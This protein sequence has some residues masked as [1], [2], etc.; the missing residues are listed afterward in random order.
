MM[1]QVLVHEYSPLLW[2]HWAKER[3]WMRR[4]AGWAGG[5]ESVDQFIQAFSFS[6][7][8]S[9]ILDHELLGRRRI[10]PEWFVVAK[11]HR[12]NYAA[13]NAP[14]HDAR[15]PNIPQ[16]HLNGD[17]QVRHCLPDRHRTPLMGAIGL[18]FR[19]PALEIV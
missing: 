2:R 9:F 15:R 1:V 8:L 16:P 10:S 17:T 5:D 6:V 19:Q 7:K 18:E 3:V 14:D 13:K 4:E 11:C 12:L